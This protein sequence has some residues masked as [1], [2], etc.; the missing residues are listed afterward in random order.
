MDDV[1]DLVQQVALP[2]ELGSHRIHVP[3]L[4]VL[5]LLQADELLV[6][7][8][9]DGQRQVTGL[10]RKDGCSSVAVDGQLLLAEAVVEPRPYQ[11]SGQ[12]DADDGEHNLIPRDERNEQRGHC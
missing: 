11:A 8:L 1:D 12:Q 10:F 4:L 2:G 9:G 5:L 3:T 6:P 7:A